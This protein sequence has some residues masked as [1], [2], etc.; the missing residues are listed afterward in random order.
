MLAK[1]AMSGDVSTLTPNATALEAAVLL[2]NTSSAAAPVVDER[3][4]LAGIVS[5]ADVMSH[6]KVGASADAAGGAKVG[7]IMT[8][9]VITVE[10]DTSLASAI[11]IMLSRHL[12]VLPVC[13]SGT[14]VGILSRPEIVRLIV[15]QAAGDPVTTTPRQDEALRRNVL[16]AV[17]GRR[18]S[19]V[20]RF[21]VVV[22]DGAIHLWGVV[23]SDTVH[24][25]YVEAA[26]KVPQVRSVTSH[27]HVM[28]GGVR[29]HM[30]V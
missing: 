8:R 30:L 19:L 2:V 9:D 5:E 20:Q 13:R 24:A 10:E 14:V 25:N 1:D 4:Q 21:D 23:P 11:D 16:Q 28:P 18:W 15:S 27:M 26:E 29:M 3:G 7:D 22:K 12:K 17:K 6:I